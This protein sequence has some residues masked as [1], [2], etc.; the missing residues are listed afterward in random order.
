M[1]LRGVKAGLAARSS[2]RA[3]IGRVVPFAES[4]AARRTPWYRSTALPWAIAATL[5]VVA[6][7]QSLQTGSSRQAGVPIALQPVTLRAASRGAEPVVHVPSSGPTAPPVSL[8]VELGDAPQGGQ[9]AY[10]LKTSDGRADVA[11]V[12]PAPAPGTP[13]LLVMPS[14]TVVAPMH[15]ILTVHDAAQPEH[16]LGEYRFAASAP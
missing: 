14:W 6:G 10:N 2:G 3:P 12:V 4:R 15:Y 1:M 5:T 8:A 9:V 16:V 13:L 7:Y 11:G